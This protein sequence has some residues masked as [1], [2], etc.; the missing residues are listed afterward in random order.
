MYDTG[1]PIYYYVIEGDTK[2]ADGHTWKGNLYSKAGS[3]S[4]LGEGGF[5]YDMW[6]QAST[7][8]KIAYSFPD[9][10]YDAA[11]SRISSQ[12]GVTW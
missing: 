12:A 9:A 10:A 4:W 2:T 11:M 5:H 8:N 7:L 6:N 1:Y 3:T